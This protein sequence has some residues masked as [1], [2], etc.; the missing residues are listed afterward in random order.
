MGRKGE[1][2]PIDPQLAIQRSGEGGTAVQEQVGVE[3]IM[4]YI[5]FLRDK[6]GL[7]DQSALVNPVSE[8]AKKLDPR[9]L[10]QVNR[11]HSH[12]RS[13]AGKLLALST[14]QKA[15]GEQRI[16]AIVDIMAEKTYQHGHAIGRKEAE[17]IGLNVVKPSDRVESFMWDLHETYEDLCHMREPIDPRAVIPSGQDE[18]T[19]HLVMG[20]IESVALSHRFESDLRVRH[21]RQVPAQLNVNLNL[22]LQLPPNVQPQQLPAAVQ[23]AV[24]QLLQQLQQQAQGLIQQEINKQMPIVGLEG[25]TQAGSWRR[26]D[27]WPDPPSGS[28]SAQAQPGNGSGQSS[29]Q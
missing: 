3:D 7:S 4:A 14:K 10:G 18:Y 6:V 21:R 1:L 16:Q 22:N 29:P 8:L 9:I 13:V 23:Q 2:G 20:A 5:R 12:I 17:E 15:L 27:A 26:T 28:G 11:A 24:Q 19:E 25:W